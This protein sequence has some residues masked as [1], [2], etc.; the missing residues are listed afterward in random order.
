MFCNNWPEEHATALPTVTECTETLV[1]G[2]RKGET[3]DQDSPAR[4]SGGAARSTWKRTEKGIHIR[5]SDSLVHPSWNN[6]PALIWIPDSETRQRILS[7]HGTLQLSGVTYGP[8][9]HSP[10]PSEE[11]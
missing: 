1:Q 5:R 3:G 11:D 9:I 10:A 8:I 7:Q 4:V 6:I 2:D